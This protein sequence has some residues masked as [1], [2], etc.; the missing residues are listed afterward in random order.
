MKDIFHDIS[1]NEDMN[2]RNLQLG[3]KA[4]ELGFLS[5]EQAHYCLQHCAQGGSLLDVAVSYSYLGPEHAQH[6]LSQVQ[7]SQSHSGSSISPE[8]GLLFQGYQVT[9]ILGQ[10]GMG[11]VF[12]VE[13]DQ[14]VYA[15]KTILPEQINMETLARFE[16]EA[17]AAASVDIHRNIV[18][19]HKLELDTETPFIVM[20][21]VEGQGLDQL[22]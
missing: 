11:A 9:Q 14:A 8:V 1:Y 16:R 21:Y 5:R 12:Q 15:L 20:D 3:Q 4:I 22:I 7:L 17:L 18:S 10:G 19:V 6:V 13:K 2:A